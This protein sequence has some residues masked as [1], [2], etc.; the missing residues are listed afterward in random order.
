MEVVLD[1]EKHIYTNVSTGEQYISVTNFISHYKKKFDSDFWSKKVAE[2]EGVSQETVLNSWKEIT[3]KAQNRG[4]KIHLVM[5][6]FL[7]EKYIEEGYEELADKFAKKISFLVKNNSKIQSEQ[8]CFDHQYKI[9]GTA[10]LIIENDNFFYILDFKTNKMFNYVSKYNE[11]FY[12]PID[13]LPQCELTTYTI[14]LSIYAYMHEM[15]T[16]KKCG[17]LKIFYMR[18]SDSRYWQEIPC[19]YMKDTVKNLF[20]DKLNKDT[21]KT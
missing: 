6:R 17:G 9:A 14:Q 19:V 20:E 12:P 13:Y 3:V 1:H 15:R 11:Y 18:E 21:I 7:K 4:T 2:R 10:D 16:K 8:I 5:E